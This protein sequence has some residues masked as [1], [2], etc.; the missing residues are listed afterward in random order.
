MSLNLH[1]TT[2]RQLHAVTILLDDLED[3]GLVT[4]KNAAVARAAV[5]RA[6]HAEHLAGSYERHLENLAVDAGTALADIEELDI[7][8]VVEAV[9]APPAQMLEKALTEVW[10]RNMRAARKAAFGNVNKAPGV[11]TERFNDLAKRTD[12]VVSK[13][14][15][16]TTAIEA[17]DLGL[18][19]EYRAI[20]TLQAEYEHLCTL[21]TNLR[22]FGLIPGGDGYTAGWHWNWRRELPLGAMKVAGQ[23]KDPARE[24]FLIA[25]RNEPYCAAS[26]GEATATMNAARKAAA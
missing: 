25:I 24:R 11:L 4:A 26:E 13:L 15:V 1:E 17:I 18:A 14:G 2:L 21:R 12:K 9:T 23:Q 19:N 16:G 10:H 22:S 20:S 8:A 7:K 6:R 5:T 3:V